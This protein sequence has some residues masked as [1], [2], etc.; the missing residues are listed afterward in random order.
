MIG[1]WSVP[2]LSLITID[3]PPNFDIPLPSLISLNVRMQIV[4]MEPQT[5]ATIFPN[6]HKLSYVWE[7]TLD[8]RD[9]WKRGTERDKLE[10]IDLDLRSCWSTLVMGSDEEYPLLTAADL[11][12]SLL[13]H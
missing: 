5:F 2:L 11:E 1:R 8:W 3:G 12:E 7:S 4:D 13:M 9:I 10:I 6:L